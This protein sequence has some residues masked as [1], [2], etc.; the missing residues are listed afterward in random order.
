MTETTSDRIRERSDVLSGDEGF[1]A[2]WKLI[3][4]L[5]EEIDQLRAEMRQHVATIDLYLQP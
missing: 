3:L 5:A 4:A 2:V 1:V